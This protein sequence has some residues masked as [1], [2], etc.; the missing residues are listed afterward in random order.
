MHLLQLPMDI[1]NKSACSEFGHQQNDSTLP[2][3]TN[4]KA[5][6]SFAIMVMVV[7]LSSM[8]DAC[9]CQTY[10]SAVMDRDVSPSNELDG[11]YPPDGRRTI[12]KESPEP[13]PANEGM[14]LLAI[15]QNEGASGS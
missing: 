11:R 5:E 9:G 13:H 4:S 1:T 7:F 15:P 8:V 10:L 6:L 3:P 12:L 2:L 14:K